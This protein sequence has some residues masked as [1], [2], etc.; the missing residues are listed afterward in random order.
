MRKTPFTA[1]TWKEAHLKVNQ[2]CSFYHVQHRKLEN[3]QT[4]LKQALLL[5]ERVSK[6]EYL[7]HSIIS[8]CT[9]R[10]TFVALFVR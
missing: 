8:D 9:A 4:K 3:K 2:L 10:W 6:P 1:T 7:I 5:Q